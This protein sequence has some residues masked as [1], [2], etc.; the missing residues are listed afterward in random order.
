MMIAVHRTRKN[1]LAQ[2]SVQV[3]FLSIALVLCMSDA[4]AATR[5]FTRTFA[6]SAAGDI[7]IAANMSLHCTTSTVA[8]PNSAGGTTTP[9]APQIT[10]CNNARSNTGGVRNN[11]VVMVRMDI[12]SNAATTNSTSAKLILP[13][14]STVAFAGL[15]WGAITDNAT[16]RSAVQFATP[17]SGGA[18][19]TVSATVTDDTAAAGAYQSYANVTNI[20]SLAGAGTY[21]VANMAT[22]FGRVN[23]HAGWSLV[24]VYENPVEPTRNMVVYDG[25][26]NIGATNIDIPLAGFITP[27]APAL[28]TS[29]IGLV[30]Y[31]GD[32]GA[33]EGA[34]TTGG[35]LFGP[36][37]TTLSPVTNTL[38]PLLDAHNSTI[39]VNSGTS[40]AAT[41]SADRSPGFQ[42][43]LG[44]DAD[45]FSPNVQL[46]NSAT[47]AFVRVSGGTNEVF[48][49]GVITIATTV[50]VPNIKDSF[51]K[52][53]V[54]LNGGALVVGDT[55]EYT[56]VF[57]NTG[58]DAAVNI[59]LQDAIPSNTSYVTG[60]IVL[61]SSSTGMPIGTRTDATSDDSARFDAPNNRVVL[62]VGRTATATIGGTLNPLDSQT[63][64]FRVTVNA[65]T[66]SDTTISNQATITFAAQTLGTLYTEL[67][68][69]NP[70]AAGIQP[71]TI[72][73][74]SPDL[75]IAKTHAPAA[76]AQ[77]SLLP[78][79]P[80]FSIV[81]F[82]TGT[83][84][85]FGTVTVADILPSGMTA[86]SITGA[87]WSCTLATVLCTRTDALAVGSSFATITLE[88]SASVAGSLTN[89][90][91]V[92]CACEGASKLGNNTALDP[93]TVLPTVNLTI[94]KTNGVTSLVA[95]QT[96]SYTVTVANLAGSS[97][98]AGAV[99]K[100]PAVDGLSCTVATCSATGGAVCPAPVLP[101][102]LLS[103]LQAGGL[104]ITS[105]PAASSLSF[106]INCAVTA[107]GQ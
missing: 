25:F 59:V 89:T 72:V 53:V 33:L 28:V 83:I 41:Y 71:S 80:T 23:L 63:L 92:S 54:D 7:T 18:Y 55:L 44:F 4:F 39:S 8:V 69:G 11:D 86:L 93:V 3:F 12:D 62:N 46:P 57:T 45:L 101:A 67:S 82:N 73:T 43:T 40:T 49:P 81:V 6:L 2:L 95:G 84:A 16:G 78:S 107:T 76:F 9:S 42:N 87:G 85:S 51:T 105:F 27:P 70:S 97:N 47:S 88:V 30:S 38:N 22:A 90:A 32:K 26:L 75:R 103:E 74:A 91:N 21:T 29:K 50:F 20:V 64:K 61:S 56:L 65:N 5:A 34:A 102:T 106:A 14:G 24:V 13:A 15:Y 100:D 96:I 94:T 48:Y 77:S 35:L 98:A 66:P 19:Q 79:T 58:N 17:S 68:D 37:I 36:T 52:T 99:V 1:Q 104:T 10:A 60:S 31:D